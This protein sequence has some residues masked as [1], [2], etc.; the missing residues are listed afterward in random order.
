[1]N[2]RVFKILCTAIILAFSLTVTGS[3][4]SPA[5]RS[6]A[7]VTLTIDTHTREFAIPADFIGLGF[8]TRSATPD[9]Y[10]VHGYFFSP[11]NIQL[12]TL[13]RNI[14]IHNIRIGGGTVDGSGV[15][16]HCVTP[17][18]TFKDIDNLFAFA[19]AADVKVIYSVRL[20]NVD[21]CA[22][23]R[24]AQNDA[25]IVRYI[26]RRYRDRLE[27]FSIGNEP[28]VRG[29]HSTPGHAVDSQIYES[30]PGVAGSA[31]DSYF[32]QWQQ[33]ARVIRKAAPGAKFSGPDTAVSDKSS[34]T[35]NPSTGV[36]WTVQFGRD[37]KS[38]GTLAETLQH[39]YVWG[40]PTGTPPQVAID[41]ML[42][43]AWDDDADKGMQPAHNGGKA[44]FHPYPYVYSTVLAPLVALGV[45]YR[46]TEA[47]DCLHGVP[48]ASDGF[49]SALW[50]LD[51]MHW[52]AAHHMAG[53]N[54]HNNP[55]LPTDTIVPNPN[56]CGPAGCGNYR[57][58]PKAYGM[59]AFDLGSSGYVEPLSISNPLKINLT[60]YAVGTA[61]DLYVTI[62]NKTHSS[63]SDVADAAVTIDVP[64]FD[65]SS[66]A[67]ILLT[68]GEPGNAATMTAT[69]GGSTITADARWSGS[70]TPLD[71]VQDGKLTVKVESTT[72][73]VVRIHAEQEVE[74]KK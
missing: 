59:K 36:S 52:W 58:S 15:E 48:G 43:S 4:Q 28:D 23:H 60:A 45:P 21:A 16:E 46:M 27:S 71:R 14:G 47:N 6:Q 29:Y 73:V 39:H 11:D 63:T 41:D 74:A 34:F 57:V 5:M 44:E 66:A 53:V 1:M 33:V 31:Y 18:P 10:G 56:P 8:E 70:W 17:T 50:A 25:K 68:G 54:F 32:A 19:R 67:A 7:P 12:I 64:G 22:D 55:W 24:L 13:F 62:I 2:S 37:L 9:A 42:S 72:A 40:I 49:A 35:P 26:W 51:Y 30:K 38:S 3:A 69:L 61:R 20:L 65:G